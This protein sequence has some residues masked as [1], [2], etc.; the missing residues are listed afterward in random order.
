MQ[1]IL[2]HR[3]AS[4][5]QLQLHTREQLYTAAGTIVINTHFV[6]IEFPN[7]LYIPNIKVYESNLEEH[8]IDMLIGMDIISL[9]DFA[10]TNYDGQTKYLFRYPS[11]NKPITFEKK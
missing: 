9:G 11:S 5:L 6:D 4:E 3:I 10:V 7:G 8:G 1:H 2:S